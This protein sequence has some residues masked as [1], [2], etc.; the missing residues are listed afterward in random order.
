MLG[1]TGVGTEPLSHIT[2]LHVI[3]S[4]ICDTTRSNCDCYTLALLSLLVSSLPAGSCIFC[5]HSLA[6]Q[7]EK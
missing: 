1:L 7:L 5:S 3:S 6:P 4:R 2:H